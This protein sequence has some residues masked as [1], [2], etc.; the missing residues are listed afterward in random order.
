MRL[1]NKRS[2]LFRTPAEFLIFCL[3]IILS[4]LGGYSAS[5]SSVKQPIKV[6]KLVPANLLEWGKGDSEYAI[7]VDKSRQKIMV[8]RSNYLFAPEKVYKCSTGEND[9]PKSK[10]NDRRTP[11][12]IYFFT[13]NVEKKYL[14]PIYGSRALPIDYPNLIDEKE[15]NSGY[16]IWLHGTN[17]PLKPK[18]TNGCI[19]LDNEDIEEMS[20][21]IKLFETPIIIS[22]RIKLVPP[23]ELEKEANKIKRIIE[24]WRSSWQGKDIETYMSLYNR[25]FTSGVKN[26]HAW[27]DYK[28]R[29]AQKYKWINVKID[30]LRLLSNDGVIL[31]IFKQAY[32]TPSFESRGM[33]RLY[34]TKNSNEW[35]ITGEFFR[36]AEKAIVPVK[37]P[38]LFS[39]RE[40]EDFIHL[41]KDSWETKDLERYIFCYDTDFKSRNMDLS[42]WKNHRSRLNQKY[43]SLD[44]QISHLKIK[45]LT[46]KTVEV[47]FTQDYRADGYRDLGVKKMLLVKEGKEWKIKTEDWSPIKRKSRR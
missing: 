16:G 11:E 32:S 15:G 26:W 22:S 24:K 2:P 17:K 6:R 7:L 10:K 4:T 43:Q 27:R 25:K 46:D 8:Y 21:V 42:A 37:K 12:G 1:K 14:S 29:L 39:R 3:F 41:W 18:D 36:G 23:S 19:V 34:F 38:V 9:G 33:K 28:S 5:A 20:S 45:R 31:A 47:R 35:K 30:N 40:V 44:I 13:N